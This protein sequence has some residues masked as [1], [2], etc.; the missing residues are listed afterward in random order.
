MKMHYCLL[1]FIFAIN[2]LLAQVSDFADVNFTRADNIAQIHQGASLDNLPLLAYQLTSTLSTD[3][4]K[5]RAIYKWVCQ[6]IK[7]DNRQ[8]SKVEKQRKKLK[9]DSVSFMKWNREYKKIAFKKLLQH[10]TTMCTGYAYL[11]KELCFLAD[12]RCQII[13]GYARSVATNTKKIEYPNHSWNA[14]FLGNKWYLCDPTWSSGYLNQDNLFVRDYN[15]GYFLTAPDLF[16]KNHYPLQ[17]EWLLDQEKSTS[18]FVSAPL[19]YDETI[20]KGIQPVY[21]Q[22]MDITVQKNEEVSF[23][24]SS[25]NEVSE[26]DVQLVYYSGYKERILGIYDKLQK[27]NIISFKH[28]FKTKG[29]YDTHIKIDGEIVATYTIMVTKG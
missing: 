26:K 27:D 22:L 23:S 25:T 18:D 4:E 19:I 12:I 2:G 8:F 28:T 1:L 3:V 29:T 7:G 15:D 14:V 24:L 17:T 11:I 21:P 16:A 5:F 20:E 9:H 13:D 6:N 10:K